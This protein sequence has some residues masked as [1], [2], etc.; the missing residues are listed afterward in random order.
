MAEIL[1]DNSKI[2]PAI[3]ADKI[4]SLSKEDFLGWCSLRKDR[5]L[6]I[7]VH[8][9]FKTHKLMELFTS[10]QL[11]FTIFTVNHHDIEGVVEQ[12]QNY[13]TNHVIK[14]KFKSYEFGA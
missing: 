10:K 5:P 12:D 1:K 13:D 6:A 3:I 11:M 2:G 14:F 4:K 8:E 7:S 9:R